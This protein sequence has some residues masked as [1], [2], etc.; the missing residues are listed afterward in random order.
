MKTIREMVR[1]DLVMIQSKL[2]NH[3]IRQEIE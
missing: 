3:V 1:G 2:I